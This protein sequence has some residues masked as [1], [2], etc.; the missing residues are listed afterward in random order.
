M[1]VERLGLAYTEAGRAASPTLIKHAIV[2]IERN[3]NVTPLIMFIVFS[4]IIGFVD[5]GEARVACIYAPLAT[6]AWVYPVGLLIEPFSEEGQQF[7][8]RLEVSH[9]SRGYLLDA[10]EAPACLQIRL[11]VELQDKGPIARI[12]RLVGKTLMH[13]GTHSLCYNSRRVFRN[14][15]TSPGKLE[16]LKM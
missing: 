9:F 13:R 16:N 11:A 10:A 3:V 2:A 6:L 5:F 14:S 4:S 7:F 15:S 8:K 1:L 12:D